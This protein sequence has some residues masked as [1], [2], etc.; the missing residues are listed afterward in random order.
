M[1]NREVEITLKIT[2]CYIGE[3]F[4]MFVDLITY[5]LPLGIYTILVTCDRMDFLGKE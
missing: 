5:A 2:G 4:C 3:G 1:I